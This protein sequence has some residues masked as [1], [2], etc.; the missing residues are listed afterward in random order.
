MLPALPSQCT[1]ILAQKR[2][3]ATVS[4]KSLFQVDLPSKRPGCGMRFTAVVAG[5]RPHVA[6]DGKSYWLGGD[7]RSKSTTETGRQ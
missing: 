5:G 3:V 4:M 7:C 6:P 1:E 2:S